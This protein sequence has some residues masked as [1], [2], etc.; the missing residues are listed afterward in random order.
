[1]TRRQLE[2]NIYKRR[3]AG[4]DSSISSNKTL[5]KLCKLFLTRFRELFLALSTIRQ[6]DRSL[7]ELQ[8][9]TKHVWSAAR[10]LK[11][12]NNSTC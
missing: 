8:Q 11:D 4:K 3:L 9:G 5:M 6:S 1:M 12:P 7:E 10:L 2:L